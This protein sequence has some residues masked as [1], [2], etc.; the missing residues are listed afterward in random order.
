M[1]THLASTSCE[2]RRKSLPP[3]LRKRLVSS[4]C[5]TATAETLKSLRVVTV[6]KQARC[7]NLNECFNAGTATFMIMGDRCTRNCAFCAVD[8]SAH[9]ATLDPGEPHRIAQ[10][11][12]QLAL[13][14]AVLTSVTR[15]DLPDGGAEHFCRTV[16]AIKTANP[17]CQTEVLT[18]D[19]AGRRESVQRVCSAAPNVYNHNLET[20]ERLSPQIRSGADYSRSLQVLAWA[21]QILPASRTKSGLMVGLGETDDEVVKTMR[22][23]RAVNCD[24]LTIG[25][26]LRPTARHMPVIRFVQ[27][28]V[29]ADY[30]RIGRK[31]GFF[32]VAA[33]PF[34]RSSYR[35]AELTKPPA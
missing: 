10:A 17:N 32:A 28:S 23:L 33:G 8:S 20:V 14:Y 3:W 13:K 9:P 27:P 15:D 19:F 5:F 11:V 25:Q 30:E 6:C 31:L 4:A 7:P 34:V 16:T 18:P 29:F 24:L 22:D 2:P 26:Y 35:A 21:R 12:Q 1:K